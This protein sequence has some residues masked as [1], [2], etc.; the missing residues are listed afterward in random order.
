L[1]RPGGGKT[2]QTIYLSGLRLGILAAQSD[3]R[4]GRKEVELRAIPGPAMTA[5]ASSGGC[6]PGRAVCDATRSRGRGHGRLDCF[7]A[8]FARLCSA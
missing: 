8:Q 1:R 2:V 4:R 6:R 7:N 3:A 5:R